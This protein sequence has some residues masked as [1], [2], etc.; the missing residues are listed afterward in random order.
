MYSIT[1]E[2]NDE[3]YNMMLEYMQAFVPSAKKS[4]SITVKTVWNDRA[5]ND[6]DLDNNQ[7]R[8]PSILQV[9]DPGT[10]SF[11]H[12]A[13]GRT[14]WISRVKDEKEV[15]AIAPGGHL[16][17]VK[18]SITLS[19]LG[20]PSSKTILLDVVQMAL[21]NYFDRTADTKTII[22]APSRWGDEWSRYHPQTIRPI[23]SVIL[24]GGMA[25]QLIEDAKR[26][27]RSSKFYASLG[28]PWQR[29]YLLHGPP[30][31]GK[32]SFI[33]ALAGELNLSVCICNLS[34]PEMSDMKLLQL[35]S[36]VPQKSII[37][38]EDID[39]AFLKRKKGDENKSSL[40]FSGLLNALDGIA[41]QDGRIV[42]MSTNH[43]DR[44]SPALIR[45]G[46]VDM[47]L[48]FDFASEKQIRGMFLKFYR[49]RLDEDERSNH[50]LNDKEIDEAAEEFV[51]GIP[52]RVVTTAQLQCLL[53]E[54]RDDP[55]MAIANVPAF[56]EKAIPENKRNDED[57]PSVHEHTDEDEDG[58]PHSDEDGES[59]LATSSSQSAKSSK[60]HRRKSRKTK[61]PHR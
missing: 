60:K 39:A 32:T 25:E 47:R 11:R 58:K 57:N 59:S 19:T 41:S 20:L 14:V 42:V 53:M 37:L 55:L 10:F 3:A 17:T 24:D 22:Y 51:K 7:P 28:I 30:G 54:F 1:I 44:L 8:K 52:P 43:I 15:A 34:V 49:R 9:P 23:E 38:L 50:S 45:P 6:D 4:R 2:H 18:E 29:G 12:P 13:S 36:S 48:K 40:T 33:L 35:F 21:D 16:T 5:G 26:F 61:K 31:T 56:L 27:M 46:R